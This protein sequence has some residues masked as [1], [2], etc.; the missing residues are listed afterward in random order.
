[1]QK[2]IL[3]PE[4]I[5]YLPE[6]YLPGVQVRSQLI[7]AL[8]LLAVTGALVAMPF[9]EV[10]VSVQSTGV[11]R[12]LGE[13]T[14]L[15]SLVS[16]RIKTVNVRENQMVYAGDTL[17]TV[18]TDELDTQLRLSVFDEED[19][20][21][22][23]ADL[24]KLTGITHRNVYDNHRLS[25]GLYAQQLNVL[26]TRVQENA[27]AQQK[28]DTELA[29]DRKLYAEKII[30][31][32]ELDN[33]EYE[34]TQ[35]K[36]EYELLF[37]RQISQWQTDMNELRLQYKQRQSEREQINEQRRFYS[38][39]A[40]VTGH[41]QQLSGKYEG[42]YLQ[43]GESLAIISPDSSLLAECY[44][45]PRDIGL[46]KPGMPVRFQMDAFNYNEWGLISGKITEI[47]EDFV[48]L[49]EQPVFKVKCT[50]DKTTLA[51]KNGYTAT[52]KK[53]MTAR[54]RFIVARRSVFQLLYDK[55][56][57]W[58]NPGIKRIV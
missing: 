40:P 22:R 8:L 43:S 51:L 2:Q 9:V 23:I 1:M 14:E 28:T 58:V 33:K 54:A 15:K 4:S 21:Q 50:L 11:V 44:V 26:R 19:I 32:R 46:L 17:F 48:L 53:G 52:L 6:A 55:V 16:G 31:K 38:I 47:A 45:S 25:T 24:Q 10:D 49:N 29:S 56:D 37:Q 36:A 35:L 34:L 57:D 13:K 39:T 42:S 12:T 30:S 41:L 5:D 20:T 7:Y 18:N 3:P 27:F